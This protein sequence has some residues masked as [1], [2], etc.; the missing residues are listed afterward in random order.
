MAELLDLHKEFHLG[1]MFTYNVGKKLANLLCNK[2]R[3][4]LKYDNAELP[5]FNDDLLN[6]EIATSRETHSIPNNFF[7]DDV[8]AIFQNYFMLDRWEYPIYNPLAYPM[9]IGTFVDF[10]QLKSIEIKPIPERKYDFSFV[11]QI[12][13]TGTRDSFKRNIE[14]LILK[15][16]KKFKYVLEFTNGFNNGLS[17]TEYVELLN[18]SKIALCPPGAYSLETFRFFECIKMGAIPMV[19]RLPKLWY[20]ENAPFFKCRWHELDFYLSTSLNYLN[21]TI[22]RNTFEKLAIYNMNILD[23]QQLALH[24]YKVLQN[25]NNIDK[26]IIQS[27]I[28]KIRR[29][30][31]QYV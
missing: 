10:D 4:I 13:H 19:E 25:R 5:T 12:P 23:E 14:Q 27:E 2:F 1:N 8:Y 15:T 17:H 26:T 29:E 3:V 30:L 6:I 22:S 24:L 31:E 9:P 7:R 28:Q 18:D 21:S 16:G 20:Y 11:G